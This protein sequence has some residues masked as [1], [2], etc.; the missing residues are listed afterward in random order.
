MLFEGH[1]KA[2]HC[3]MKYFYMNAYQQMKNLG[4]NYARVC[5]DNAKAM[6]GHNADP[7]QNKIQSKHCSSIL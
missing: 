6:L 3:G 4:E 2:T 1:I 7:L 5:Y